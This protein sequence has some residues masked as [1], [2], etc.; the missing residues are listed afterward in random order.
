MGR[1][2]EQQDDYQP[3]GIGMDS[4]HNISTALDGDNEYFN[5]RVARLMLDDGYPHNFSSMAVD[6]IVPPEM[7]AGAA[8]TYHNKA[9]HKW[10][11]VRNE[12]FIVINDR[13]RDGRVWITVNANSEA[14]A[15]EIAVE[16]TAQLTAFKGA[17]VPD[18]QVRV[19]FW[20]LTA[21]G[22]SRRARKLDMPTWDEIRG[23]Y[24]PQTAGAIDE[25]MTMKDWDD[26]RGKL[27]IWR[28]DPGLGKTY[29][30]RAMCDNW[31]EWASIHYIVDPEAF[32]SD[33]DYLYSVMGFDEDEMPGSLMAMLEDEDLDEEELA[34]RKSPITHRL[35]ILEDAGELVGA[36]ARSQTGQALSRL[37]NAVDGMF[38]QGTKCVLMITTN[39]EKGKLHE[40]VGR[41]GRCA[42]D[43]TFQ[44]FTTQEAAE[45]LGANGGNP[46]D[47][48]ND[49]TL[50]DLYAAMH[51]HNNTAGTSEKS[52]G[53]AMA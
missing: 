2:R 51:H 9:Q 29:A 6:R 5:T 44:A 17:E 43:V 14:R 47:A 45:W 19:Y 26:S 18:G 39:E 34:K 1:F 41:P 37:L 30:L 48:K 40:A 35:I 50:S 24:K 46:L 10:L 21:R 11:L 8:C 12:A 36:E 52:I 49:M 13:P 4:V 32:L 27:L 53:F 31:S 23:N 33:P 42:K 7:V 3:E 28:G 20:N 22:P 25:F 38:G 16:L 15:Q